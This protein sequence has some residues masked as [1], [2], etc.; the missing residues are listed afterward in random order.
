MLVLYATGEEGSWLLGTDLETFKKKH[1]E[2]MKSYQRKLDQW[3]KED[4]EFEKNYKSPMQIMLEELDEAMKKN[5]KRIQ[6]KKQEEKQQAKQIIKKLD[7][8]A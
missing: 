5:L 6:K 1:S 8:N 4:E 7:I 2:L 3:R